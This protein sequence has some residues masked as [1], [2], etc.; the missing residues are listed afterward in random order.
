M[1]KGWTRGSPHAPKAVILIRL[2]VGLVFLEEGVQKFL[3]PGVMGAGRFA[4]IGIPAPQAMAPFVSVIE[5][6]CGT[7]LVIGPR[8]GK[9]ARCSRGS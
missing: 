9:A 8:G 2:L 3:F 1:C 7:M 5:T 4:R 6:V